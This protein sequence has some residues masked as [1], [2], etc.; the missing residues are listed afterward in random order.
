MKPLILA[1][2]L[3]CGMLALGCARAARH[4]MAD[5]RE[6]ARTD[7]IIRVRDSIRETN[8]GRD[9]SGWMAKCARHDTNFA[10]KDRD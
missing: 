10:A 2:L 4:R 1:A 7:S 8:A 3:L 6:E 5:L 9:W